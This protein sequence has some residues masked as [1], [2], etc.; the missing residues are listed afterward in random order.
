LAFDEYAERIQGRQVLIED[1]DNY[2]LANIPST[3]YQQNLDEEKR[4]LKIDGTD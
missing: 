1:G 2:I 4:I 3:T